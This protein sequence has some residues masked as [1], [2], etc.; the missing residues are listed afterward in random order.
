MAN[1]PNWGGAE[2]VGFDYSQPGQYLENVSAARS[3]I[4]DADFATETANMTKQNIL[5]QAASSILAR[6]TSVRSRP[7]RCWV[8]KT[9]QVN[10]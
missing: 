6:P 3:R 8:A 5:Q 4:R 1:A 9:V 10:L 2:P 7:C